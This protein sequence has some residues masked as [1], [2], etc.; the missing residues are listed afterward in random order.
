MTFTLVTQT[1]S[2]YA[3]IMNSVRCAAKNFQNC[4]ILAAFCAWTSGC[5]DVESTY[6]T[7]DGQALTLSDVDIEIIKDEI[8]RIARDHTTETSRAD[9]V[10]A[11]AELEPYVL[12][13][14]N[15]FKDNRP[16][17]EV[18]LTSGAWESLWYDDENIDASE[19]FQRLNREKIFQVVYT[20]GTGAPSFYYNVSESKIRLF[21]IRLFTVRSFLRGDY[22][23]IDPATS[24]TQG[25]ARRNVISLEFGENRARLGRLRD[26]TNVLPL[27]QDVITGRR[28]GFKVPGP[29]GITGELWNLYVDEDLRISAGNQEGEEDV[30]DLYILRRNAI[31]GAP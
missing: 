26:G 8:V 31:V 24:A 21:G 20:S 10:A 22:A 28:D 27:T 30:L 13:L 4:L 23:L 12:L 14:A 1:G 29:K 25:Q 9:I 6:D 7:S 3:C 16:N 11:R 19:G 17:N 15:H 2:C 5:E 18:A